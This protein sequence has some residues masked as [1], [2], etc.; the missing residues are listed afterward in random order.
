MRD[1]V[2]YR[3]LREAVVTMHAAL[4]TLACA[5]AMDPEPGPA[6]LAWCYACRFPAASWIAMSVGGWKR[7]ACCLR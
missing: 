6:I 1:T 3:A 2:I 4:A 5:L 7:L